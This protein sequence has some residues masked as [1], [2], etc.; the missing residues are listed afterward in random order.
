MRL[1]YFYKLLSLLLPIIFIPTSSYA[2][3]LYNATTGKDTL[4]WDGNNMYPVPTQIITYDLDNSEKRLIHQG[5][6]TCN[7]TRHRGPN[8]TS[9]INFIWVIKERMSRKLVCSRTVYNKGGYAIISGNAASG[10][11]CD[12]YRDEQ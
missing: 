11:Q 12:V 3:C 1:K 5:A 4:H 6:Y 10:F 9:T 2:Y 8:D 7:L